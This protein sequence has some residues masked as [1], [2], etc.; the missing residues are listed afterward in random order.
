MKSIK[1]SVGNQH[2]SHVSVLIIMQVFWYAD[3]VIN[4]NAF[5]IEE[6]IENGFQM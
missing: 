6:I 4:I 2:I 3:T 1:M 5:A